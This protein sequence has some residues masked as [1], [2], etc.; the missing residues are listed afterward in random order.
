MRLAQVVIRCDI[1]RTPRIAEFDDH[2]CYVLYTEWGRI[3]CD[4]WYRVPVECVEVIGEIE[5]KK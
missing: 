5:W 2:G 3:D 4:P 1:D